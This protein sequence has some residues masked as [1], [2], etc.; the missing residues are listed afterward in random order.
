[1]SRAD[2][3]VLARCCD[4]QNK[5]FIADGLSDPQYCLELFRLALHE[6]VDEAW[7]QVIA[8][9]SG[10]VRGWLHH[11][12]YQRTVLAHSTEELLLHATFNRLFERT[13]RGLLDV[14][15][16]PGILTYLHMCLNSVVMEEV[17]HWHDWPRP[18]PDE[19]QHP[20]RSVEDRVISILDREALWQQVE[21]YITDPKERLLCR[22]RWRDGLPPRE[23]V[24]RFPIEFPS[25]TDVYRMLERIL[26]QLK[27]HRAALS[28]AADL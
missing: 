10:K 24:A 8:C 13:T 19:D 7:A 20:R 6:A 27:H 1:M 26:I 22:L 18:L 17:R 11:H 28:E 25:I 14:S 5:R 15:S 16:L 3:V 12:P 9:F 2:I 23:I 4:E 21:T